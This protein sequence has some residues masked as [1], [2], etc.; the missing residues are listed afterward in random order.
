MQEFKGLGDKDKSFME[1]LHQDG[2]RNERRLNYATIYEAKHKSILKTIRLNSLPEVMQKKAEHYE[3]V[4]RKTRPAANAKRAVKAKLAV[5]I[6]TIFSIIS[7][8]SIYGF[9][10]D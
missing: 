9:V 8:I 5:V 1:L 4:S 2:S 10:Q 6:I 7:F 3:K